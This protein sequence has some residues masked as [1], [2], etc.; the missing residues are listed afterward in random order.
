MTNQMEGTGTFRKV[1]EESGRYD[2][3]DIEE[4]L[5]EENIDVV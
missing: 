5:R 2:K 3:G 4:C 1:K